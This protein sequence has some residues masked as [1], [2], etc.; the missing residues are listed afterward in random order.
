[1]KAIVLTGVSSGI[2]LATAH[3]LIKNGYHVFG[4]VRKPEDA[5]RLE[6][7][8][9]NPFHALHFDVT[10]EA[11]VKAAAE[12]VRQELKGETLD[13]LVNNAGFLVI[14]PLLSNAPAEVRKVLEVNV[15]GVLV[16]TQAF[17]PLLGADRSLRGRS[18]KVINVGSILGKVTL[19]FLG[20][21]CASKFAMEA[22]TDAMRLELNIYGIAVSIIRPGPIAT[23]MFEAGLSGLISLSKGTDY[24]LLATRAQAIYHHIHKS[25]LS[26]DRVAK[27][28][29]QAI[30]DPKPCPSYTVESELMS[31]IHMMLPKS[32][33]QKIY[34]K[35]FGLNPPTK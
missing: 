15:T 25:A 18:G 31:R 8:F 24:E 33:L 22:L 34:M 27:V 17:A 1:M 20:P 35:Q 3:A 7:Q 6:K 28:I 5:H 13:A 21:Y 10:D 4:S 12:K 14:G 26:P 16:V 23:P 29:L 9:G 19:P 11:A 32:V 30:S 2:G